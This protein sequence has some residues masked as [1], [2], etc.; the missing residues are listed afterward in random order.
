VQQGSEKAHMAHRRW[1]PYDTDAQKSKAKQSKATLSKAKQG[2][3]RIKTSD[4]LA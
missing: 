2:K 4:W 3:A 1:V